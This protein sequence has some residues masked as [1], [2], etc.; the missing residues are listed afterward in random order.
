[1][2]G[3]RVFW[4]AIDFKLK[5]HIVTFKN[6]VQSANWANSHALLT[7][8]GTRCRWGGRRFGKPT[9]SP[10]LLRGSK[11]VPPATHTSCYLCQA[12]Q[13]SGLHHSRIQCSP[14]ISGVFHNS[15]NLEVVESSATFEVGFQWW[16]N[17][18]LKYRSLKSQFKNA[19]R[20]LLESFSNL[21][22]WQLGQKFHLDW[23]FLIMFCPFLKLHVWHTCI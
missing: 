17:R 11:Q 2:L 13:G 19:L 23:S 10:Q 18:S 8:Q 9:R 15:E 22:F 12:H 5:A 16:T 1:M 20:S 7:D 4:A 14:R 6:K 21:I 3:R